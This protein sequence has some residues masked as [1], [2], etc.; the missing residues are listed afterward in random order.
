[1]LEGHGG[2]ENQKPQNQQPFVFG[3]AV[4]GNKGQQDVG[5]FHILLVFRRQTHPSRLTLPPDSWL[6][7]VFHGLLIGGTF[8][9]PYHQITTQTASVDD[10]Q[11][12]KNDRDRCQTAVE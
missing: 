10:A 8:P 3:Y 9:L 2:N 11:Q 7:I 6:D 12:G 5:S 1:M 4:E